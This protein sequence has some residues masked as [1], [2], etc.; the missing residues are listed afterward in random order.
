M[1]LFGSTI[2]EG[3]IL[4]VTHAKDAEELTIDVKKQ[5]AEKKKKE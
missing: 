1:Q 4:I 5:K 3:D 2:S